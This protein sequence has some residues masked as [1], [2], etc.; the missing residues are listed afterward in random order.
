MTNFE[1]IKNMG[2]E[3]LA[4][5]I[6]GLADCRSCPIYC[7]DRNCKYAWIQFLKSEVEESEVE[8]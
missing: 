4:D 6:S 8:E 5:Y 2:V 7:G 3:E 1:K